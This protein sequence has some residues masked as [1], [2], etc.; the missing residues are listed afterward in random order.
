LAHRRFASSHV[1]NLIEPTA[2]A[3]Q[4]GPQSRFERGTAARRPE[5]LAAVIQKPAVES[6]IYED[7]FLVGLTGPGL[8]LPVSWRA[9]LQRPHGLDRI[10]CRVAHPAGNRL[11][12]EAVDVLQ[13]EFARREVG[14]DLLDDTMMLD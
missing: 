9:P 14:T 4:A 3:L 6:E 13:R 7:D 8:P 5:P 11:V 10:G 1:R 12:V 2:Q